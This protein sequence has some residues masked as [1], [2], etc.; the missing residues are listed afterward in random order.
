MLGGFQRA[1]EHLAASLDVRLKRPVSSVSVGKRGVV[2]LET[3]GTSRRADIAVVALPHPALKSGVVRVSG[4]PKAS[5]RGI[6]QLRTG[7]L[8]RVVLRFDEPWWTASGVTAPGI[9]LVG[10]RWSEWYDVSANTGIS[11]LVGVCGGR[12]ADGMPASDTG[13]VAEAVSELTRALAN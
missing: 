6:A 8:E 11:T 4:L 12:A 5:R 1:P 13:V 2:V 9:G 10:A 7:N 3:D